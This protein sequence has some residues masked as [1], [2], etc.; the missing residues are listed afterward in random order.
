MPK[1][2]K[3]TILLV[4]DDSN[5]R[6]VIKTKLETAGFIVIEASNG[7]E[8]FEK[9]KELKPDLVLMDVQMP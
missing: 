9:T 1:D 8:G 3:Y 4:D 2:G 6:E 7:E 5:F